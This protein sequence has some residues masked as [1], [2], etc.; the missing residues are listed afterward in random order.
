M[1][2]TLNG[3]K[4][5]RKSFKRYALEWLEEAR[6]EL[7]E[8]SLAKYRNVVELYLLPSL[9]EKRPKDF[10]RLN[11][12]EFSSR[13]LSSGGAKGRGLQ[14]S[15][16]NTVL[17]VLK[18]ILDYASQKTDFPT[19]S[20]RKLR[21]NVRKPTADVL[22]TSEQKRLW[23]YLTT[24]LSPCSIGMLLSVAYGLRIGEIC[25]LRWGDIDLEKGTLSITRMLT[26]KQTFAKS[27]KKTTVSISPL[28]SAYS[29]RKIPL[30]P[31]DVKLLSQRKFPDDA[32]VL[33]GNP[34]VY[35]EPRTLSNRFK[36]AL[37]T[38]GV[39]NVNFHVLRHSFATRWIELESDVK[40]L[41]EIL[42]HSSVNVTLNY[43]VHP[44]MESKRRRVAHFSKRVFSDRKR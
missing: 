33:T 15:T 1:K 13:L 12:S 8:S 3:R 39:R 5:S 22:L 19:V 25:A 9:G 18:R 4:G 11:I 43:Y 37:R 35:M 23:D 27:G 2:K 28:K 36:K 26:R 40:I 24:D 44:S 34:D 38:C 32:Y 17:T 20:F 30:S 31:N 42:G 14:P 41:S 21:V 16:V 10:N 29:E 7:R 6:L